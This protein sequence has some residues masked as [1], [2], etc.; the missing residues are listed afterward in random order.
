MNNMEN[1]HLEALGTTSRFLEKILDRIVA[2]I[3][4]LVVLF[5]GYSLWNSY[6]L[7]HQGYVDD[8]ILK[9]KP[10]V[11]NSGDNPSLYDLMKINKDTIGWLTVDDT[12]IDYPLVIGEDNQE[13][14]NQDVYNK[15]SL[16]GSIFLDS[17]NKRDF[18]DPYNLLYGHNIEHGGMFADVTLFEDKKFFEDHKYGR[19]Y[20]ADK[21]YDIE[22][23]ICSG[24]DAY[25]SMI[26]D[27]PSIATMDQRFALIDHM[28][29]LA[30]QKRDI[31]IRDDKLIALSTCQNASTNGRTILLGV[32]RPMN[33]V[34]DESY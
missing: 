19:L 24:A 28:K 22:F 23:F 32:L 34:R 7:Y 25:D 17:R 9:F 33:G 5:A 15:F 3:L 13:Y 11:E 21:T 16:A 8:D 30:I 20:L 1:K 2:L 12:H 31:D 4:L 14:I 18:S 26:F 6:K 29:S 10:S 27:P